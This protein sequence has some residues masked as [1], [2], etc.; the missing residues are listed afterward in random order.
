[1]AICCPGGT[2]GNSWWGVPPGSP[3]P[4]P[5][6]YPKM[7]FFTPVLRPG[8]QEIMPSLLW[9]EQQ[10][11]TSKNPF[12]IRVFL[13]LSYIF[14]IETINTFVPATAVP[15]KT[16]PDSRPKWAKSTPVFRPKGRKTPGKNPTR[17]GGTYLY[18]LYREVPP[19]PSPPPEGVCCKSNGL[20]KQLLSGS[21]I[22]QL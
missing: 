19:P 7:L 21:F 16:M 4:D 9:L 3:N 11:K 1:M 15:L 8:L 12:R 14:G 6:S 5:I 18:G 2:P 10:K 13:F 20:E 22:C 17:W